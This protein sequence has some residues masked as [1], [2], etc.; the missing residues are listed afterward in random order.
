M[1]F[2]IEMFAGPLC[3]QPIL[4]LFTGNCKLPPN[5]FGRNLVQ[6]VLNEPKAIL[7]FLI[8]P[9]SA[10][11]NQYSVNT[12]FITYFPTSEEHPSRSNVYWQQ[13]PN[14]DSKKTQYLLVTPQNSLVTCQNVDGSPM[15]FVQN[16][17]HAI[18]SNIPLSLCSLVALN[19]VDKFQKV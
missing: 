3:P 10:F 13:W 4:K 18:I 11:I 2:M 14:F 5:S 16:C 12:H 1:F 15:F 9:R 17:L 6:L 19:H 7:A 8:S